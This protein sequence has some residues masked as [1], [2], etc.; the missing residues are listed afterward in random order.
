MHCPINLN[1]SKYQETGPYPVPETMLITQGSILRILLP[2]GGGPVI[3]VLVYLGPLYPR[4]ILFHSP[5]L[6]C[7]VFKET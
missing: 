5:P 4:S 7:L 3:L 6:L 2:R 1:N